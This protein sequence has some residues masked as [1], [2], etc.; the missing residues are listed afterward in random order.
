MKWPN[1]IPDYRYEGSLNSRGSTTPGIPGLVES[2]LLPQRCSRIASKINGKAS[3][4]FLDSIFYIAYCIGRLRPNFKRQRPAMLVIRTD[5]LGDGVLSE[6]MLRAL[7]GRYPRHQFHLWVPAA[8]CE[9][10]SAAPY[11]KERRIIPR[12][13][14][15]GCLEYFRSPKWR[16]KIGWMLG[17]S[18]FDMVIYPAISPE[19]LGNWLMKS[20]RAKKR[21]A[22]EGDLFHQFNWQRTSAMQKTTMVLFKPKAAHELAR[23]ANL[24]FQCGA[25]DAPEF[26]ELTLDASANEC[27]GVLVSRWQALADARGARGLLGVVTASSVD[28]LRYPAEKWRR[29][30]AEIWHTHRLMPVFLAPSIS[31][32]SGI[33]SGELD[34]RIGVLAL[35]G[36]MRS[37]D[38]VVSLDTGPAH[39]AAA[40]KTPTVVLRH[41]G[42]PDRFFPWPNAPWVK[43][44]IRPMP[45]EGCICRCALAEAECLTR[46]EPE[47]ILEAVN[48]FFVTTARRA[49]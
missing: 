32:Q 6:P 12:G 45:C 9:L 40:M 20:V 30:L 25:Y 39:I 5:G 36:V 10:F 11:I 43:T 34:Q 38:A 35:A 49:A 33:P 8:S 23:N 1:S 41:G 21:W 42:E 47:D 28:K 29:A 31:L 17:R 3:Q 7:A 48:Q 26:P 14:K 46:I 16:W 44:L 15:N 2:R 22:V 4:F 37:M 13:F 27:A 18:R 19:P 24:A